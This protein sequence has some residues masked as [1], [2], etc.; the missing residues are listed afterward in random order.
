[1]SKA[2]CRVGCEL[3]RSRVYLHSLTMLARDG[4]VSLKGGLRRV[5]IRQLRMLGIVA[6]SR[7]TMPRPTPGRRRRHQPQAELLHPTSTCPIYSNKVAITHA[8]TLFAP[9]SIDPQR[10]SRSS[11]RSS[12]V[13][14]YVSPSTSMLP[15]ESQS[16]LD[17]LHPPK[18]PHGTPKSQ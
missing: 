15:Y 3:L 11:H 1:M 9:S 18:A 17:R 14:S 12:G 16:S 5:V 4:L 2:G 6:L 13:R 10:P 8:A 7:H